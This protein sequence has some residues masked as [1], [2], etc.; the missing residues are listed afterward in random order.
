MTRRIGIT[1]TACGLLASALM[2]L[3]GCSAT[4]SAFM[5]EPERIIIG[6]APKTDLPVD[7]SHSLAINRRYIGIWFRGVPLMGVP[8]EHHVI[9]LIFDGGSNCSFDD[10][11]C[12]TDMMKRAQIVTG[13]RSARE[14]WLKSNM[15]VGEKERIRWYCARHSGKEWEYSLTAPPAFD[16][17]G[18]AVINIDEPVGEA[19]K[20]SAANAEMTIL[21][22]PLASRGCGI[23]IKPGGQDNAAISL[24]PLDVRSTMLTSPEMYRQY[25]REHR[26]GKVVRYTGG[27]WRTE[28]LNDK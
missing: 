25:L 16:Q 23:V 24:Y 7:P 3:P 2:S 19:D 26:A 4:R 5:A 10:W 9:G 28:V 8:T 18:A 1:I 15:L 20:G 14:A 12:L 6:P 13:F 21:P 27:K 17:I 11:T 22:E